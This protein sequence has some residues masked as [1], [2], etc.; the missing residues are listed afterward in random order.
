MAADVAVSPADGKVIRIEP[1]E[2]PFTGE[3]RTCISIFMNVFSV[4][5]NRRAVGATVERMQDGRGA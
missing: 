1:K 5:G 3:Q 2:D 4:Q